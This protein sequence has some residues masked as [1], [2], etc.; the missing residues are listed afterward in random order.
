MKHL[1]SQSEF[2]SFRNVYYANTSQQ[3]AKQTSTLSGFI[4]RVELHGVKDSQDYRLL[5]A[6]MLD[7]GFSKAISNPAGMTF[8]LPTA[9]YFYPNPTNLT[10]D[11]T[12][13][14]AALGAVRAA[15]ENEFASIKAQ[16]AYPTILVTATQSLIWTGLDMAGIEDL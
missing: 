6:Y 4:V 16:N 12:V 8:K 5:R 3:G 11:E 1:L 14:R 15:L 9:T 7:N 13:Y 2:D 10:L